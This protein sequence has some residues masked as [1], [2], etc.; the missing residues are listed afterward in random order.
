MFHKEMLHD[1]EFNTQIEEGTEIIE[2][3]TKIIV[4]DCNNDVRFSFEWVY[5]GVLEF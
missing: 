5:K 3:G 1:I 2:D 4:N